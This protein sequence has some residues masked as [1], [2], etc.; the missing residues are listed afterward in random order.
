MP[1]TLVKLGGSLLTDKKTPETDRPGVIARLAQEIGAV[2]PLEGGLIVGHGSGSFG[3]VVAARF[4][5]HRGLRRPE[6]QRPGVSLTQQRAAELH[7]RVVCALAA[8]LEPRGTGP[9]SIAPSS[10]LVTAGGRPAALALEPVVL[11]LAAGLVPVI[12]G[13]IVMDREQ[14][15]AICSTEG[16]FEALVDGLPKHGLQVSKILWLGETGGVWDVDGQ[17]I[18]RITPATAEGALEAVG[19]SAGTDVTGGMRHRVETALEL[20]RRGI[21]SWIGDGREPGRLQQALAAHDIGSAAEPVPGTW[22]VPDDP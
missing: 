20:A 10:A 4:E 13:D 17:P 18:P 3:H 2:S 14:G 16:V 6:K 7:R 19:G 15:C 8:A 12:Y 21:A 9:F 5:V 1:V 11:A 22:V